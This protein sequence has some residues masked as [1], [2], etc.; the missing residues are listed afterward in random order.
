MKYLL[1]PLIALV[2]V[3]CKCGGK[4]DYARKYGLVCINEQLYQNRYEVEGYLFRNTKTH[5]DLIGTCPNDE[6]K[7]NF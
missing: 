6:I 4:E 1:L 2:F 5:L 3:A 7:V